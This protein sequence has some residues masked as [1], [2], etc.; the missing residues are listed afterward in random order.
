MKRVINELIILVN[1]IVAIWWGILYIFIFSVYR[2]GGV[3][4]E[5]NQLIA[6]I[7]YYAA[8][9]LTFWFLWQIPYRI[10]RW[11]KVTN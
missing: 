10:I 7:E 11:R 3:T 9:I 8:I 2:T 5:P 6:N 1:I 4:G